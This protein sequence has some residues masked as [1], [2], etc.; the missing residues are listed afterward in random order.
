MFRNK[1]ILNELLTAYRGKLFTLIELLVVIAIIG[2][3]ASLLL[4]ALQT[5]KKVAK[6]ALC[7]SNL[8][9]MGIA[10]IAY[11]NDF[12]ALMPQGSWCSA[13]RGYLLGTGDAGK[14]AWGTFT[15]DYLGASSS[16]ADSAYTGTNLPYDY[17]LALRFF[18]AEVV[19]CPFMPALKANSGDAANGRK[20][21]SG[22]MHYGYYNGS[23]F[24][25]AISCLTAQKL[26]KKYEG[27]SG[28]NLGG[29]PALFGDR[30]DTG[31]PGHNNSRYIDSNHKKN[32]S[33]SEVSSVLEGAAWIDNSNVVHV[34]GHVSLYNSRL[35]VTYGW[36]AKNWCYKQSGNLGD[37]TVNPSSAVFPYC[38]SNGNLDPSRNYPMIYGPFTQNYY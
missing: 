29:I 19:H 31:P 5:A 22:G 34:D 1:L 6:D 13:R 36:S 8:K 35:V 37:S 21:N 18:A 33:P 26:L 10:A 30:S 25:V 3:L 27:S 12:Q 14:L 16:K 2:I 23:S 20:T 32:G 24:D 15:Q 11:D 4:P 28:R 9:Q 17:G 7:K 38:D